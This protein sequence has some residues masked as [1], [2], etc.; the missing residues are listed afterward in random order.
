MSPLGKTQLIQQVEELQAS[1]YTVD[2]LTF[3]N[4]VKEF[5]EGSPTPVE[6]LAHEPIESEMQDVRKKRTV[7]GS[8]DYYSHLNNL[9]QLI[10]VHQVRPEAEDFMEDMINLGGRI[11]LPESDI[12]ETIKA[13]IDEKINL[14]EREANLLLADYVNKFGRHPLVH[15][16]CREYFTRCVLVFP[17]HW[18]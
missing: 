4:D 9:G 11:T 8:T 12:H 17:L 18:Q 13:V 2:R 1:F 7:P 14:K 3:R 15:A 5:L 16:A 10:N 6:K